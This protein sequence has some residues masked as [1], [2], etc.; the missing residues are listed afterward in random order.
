MRYRHAIIVGFL[1]ILL[2]G[3]KP[4]LREVRPIAAGTWYPVEREKLQAD[5]E[6][7]MAEADVPK[8]AGRCVACIVPHAP[9]ASSGAIAAAA[10]KWMQEGD[11]DRVVVLAPAHYSK[12]RGCSIP[13]AQIFITP[14][15]VVPLDTAF[16]RAAD[17]SALIEVR[18][19]DYGHRLQR[20]QLH[21]RETTVE[22]VLPFL[23]HKLKAFSVVPVIVGDFVDYDGKCD[24][25]ALDLVAE[26]LRQQIDDRTLIVVSS[27][28]THF[29]NNFAFRPFGENIVENIE[30]LDRTAFDFI[31]ARDHVGFERYLEETGNPICG[32]NA[33]SLLL[34]LLPRNAEGRLLSYDISAKRTGNTKSSISYASLAFYAPPAKGKQ[35]ETR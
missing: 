7:Y 29:G 11:Y 12:F 8:P 16:I 34:R 15:S 5:I 10:F 3:A 30:V 26:T 2:L 35:Q 13:S 21:E 24:G 28:F 25:G 20:P 4:V 23:Q 17:R 22:V 32:K 19:L 18:S 1:G 9:Y 31:L 6:K 14:M 27:D 33:I